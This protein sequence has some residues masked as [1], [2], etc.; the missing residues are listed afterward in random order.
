MLNLILNYQRPKSTSTVS[1]IPT[2]WKRSPFNKPQQC[3]DAFL[4]A[5]DGIDAPF[6]LIS[7]SSEGFLKKERFIWELER[8]GKL[9]Y[10][11]TAY[12]TYRACRNLSSRSLHVK[13]YL[14]LLEK[15]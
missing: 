15:N 10:F 5:L 9:S 1:G 8:R 7:Y 3:E 13:E 14:F 4:K 2:G 12:N 6:V 11:E